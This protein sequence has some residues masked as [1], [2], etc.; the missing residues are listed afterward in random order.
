MPNGSSEYSID[1][2][3]PAQVAAIAAFDDAIA[4]ASNAAQ[5]A[6]SSSRDRV[7]W[8]AEQPPRAT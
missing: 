8:P 3:A 2:Y 4:A 1:A 5:A 6:A 7:L